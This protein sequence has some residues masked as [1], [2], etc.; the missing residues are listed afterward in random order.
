L[1]KLI[2][3]KTLISRPPGGCLG[4][5]VRNSGKPLILWTVDTDDWRDHNTALI[6]NRIISQTRS[7]AIVLVHDI[8]PTTIPAAVQAVDTLSKRG[9]AF[10]TVSQLLGNA[11]P[12][13]AY[14]VGP[15][16]VR[17][18]KIQ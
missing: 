12:N 8:H 16:Q 5:G 17:T 2:G 13:L 15:K 10:V 6:Y 1:Y 18:M 11:Q 9:Y 3:K 14:S 4:G 7:G